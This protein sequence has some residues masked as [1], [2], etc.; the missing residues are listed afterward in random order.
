MLKLPANSDLKNVSIK[1]DRV[2][3]D[4]SRQITV[5]MTWHGTNQTQTLTVR[6]DPSRLHWLLY[7]SW[8]VEI[9]STLI[10]VTL[11]NQA[12]MV[13]LDGIPAPNENQT[14]VLAIQGFHQLTMAQTPLYD[15]DSQNVDATES[16]ATVTLKGS[17]RA[18]A[19]QLAVKAGLSSSC[20]PS[21]YNGC[22]NHTYNAPDHNFIYYFTL[23]GYGNVDYNSYVNTLNGDPTAGITLT[24]EA[25]TAKVSVS[26]TC[27]TT[28]TVDRTRSYNMKGDYSGTLTWNG[29]GF[30]SDLTWDCGKARS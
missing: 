7:P 17:I 12:G 6:K 28:V 29:S 5:S 3:D 10:R 4:S 22:F 27:N 13:S 24:V 21:K 8:R 16:S 14:A 23:P 18:S 11:P 2:I 26:A 1:S 20:D 15:T 30:D 9:P 19:L 25:A